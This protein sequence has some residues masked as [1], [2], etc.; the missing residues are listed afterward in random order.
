[1][2]VQMK[3]TLVDNGPIPT[4][5]VRPI[6]AVRKSLYKTIPQCPIASF[7]SLHRTRP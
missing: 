4:W 7:S 6:S 5:L 3:A 2:L 1:V